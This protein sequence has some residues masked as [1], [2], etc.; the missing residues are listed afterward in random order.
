MLR[1]ILFIFVL[2]FTITVNA[3]PIT[4]TA[5]T[6][7]TFPAGFQPGYQGSLGDDKWRYYSTPDGGGIRVMQA[8]GDLITDQ[9]GNTSFAWFAQLG[10][11][12]F[13]GAISYSTTV[14]ACRNGE[15]KPVTFSG[16]FTYSDNGLVHSASSSATTIALGGD[17]I[18]F[19]P[20]INPIRA[21]NS[22][23]DPYFT[24]RTVP[25]GQTPEPMTLLLLG[26][27]LAGM[28]GFL[29]KKKSKPE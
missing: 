10:Q 14:T 28:A 3:N 26:S 16:S 21:W 13:N 29:R 11:I 1:L 6:T 2:L 12:P 23:L 5:N 20:G 25:Q 19:T 7:L 15:C 27:G 18:Y 24:Y 17:F 9:Q 22:T 4:F 8:M